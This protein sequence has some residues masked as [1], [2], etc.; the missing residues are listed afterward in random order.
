MES[1]GEVDLKRRL[2]ALYLELCNAIEQR[3][4]HSD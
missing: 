3:G 1:P 4:D 2:A